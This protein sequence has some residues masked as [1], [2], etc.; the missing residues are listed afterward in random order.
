MRKTIVI[1]TASIIEALL[2]WKLKQKIKNDEIELN[3]EWKYFDIKILC[4]SNEIGHE[5]IA[6][7][8]KKET[9]QVDRLDFI[10]IIDLCLKHK[11][12]RKQFSKD[13]HDVRKLRNRLHIGGLKKMEKKYTHNDLNSVFGIA[14]KTKKIASK[15]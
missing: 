11:I 1:H 14:K 4:P 5:I 7:K 6:G 10:R 3:D 2:L 12:I 9:K 15:K 13:V 8:R